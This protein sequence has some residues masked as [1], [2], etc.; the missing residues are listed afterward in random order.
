MLKLGGKGQSRTAAY[1]SVPLAE[2]AA[3]GL[4]R[5]KRRRG[6]EQAASHNIA[7]HV[8]PVNLASRIQASSE[9][10]T[11]LRTNVNLAQE[12]IITRG[13]LGPF[14]TAAA[15]G[16]LNCG[17]LCGRRDCRTMFV[18]ATGH[19]ADT[20]KKAYE[21]LR[22]KPLISLVAGAGFEPAAF[23]L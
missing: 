10:T 15:C 21:R 1:P 3:L 2:A 5:A 14:A 22:R 19:H 17:T 23:R 20:S 9:L 13:S 4:I 18:F 6:Y 12:R 16:P 11:A 7:E 8:N